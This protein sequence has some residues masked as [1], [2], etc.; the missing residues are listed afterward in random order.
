MKNS[1]QSEDVYVKFYLKQLVGIIYQGC[2]IKIFQPGNHKLQADSGLK[3]GNAS[4]FFSPF[5]G[6]MGHDPLE[7][8]LKINGLRFPKNSFLTSQRPS[9][10]VVFQLLIPAM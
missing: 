7:N 10:S 2:I 8:F 6:D 5:Y 9:K 1:D 3:E 4:A